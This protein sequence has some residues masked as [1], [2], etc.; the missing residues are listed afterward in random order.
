MI[1]LDHKRLALLGLG[2][3]NRAL[4]AYLS[5]QGHSFA[6][7]DARER[8]GDVA[9]I[10]LGA[11]VDD[12]RLGSR[13]LERLEDFDLV[14]RTPGLPAL[15]PQLAAA[16]AAGVQVSSQTALFFDRCPAPILGVTGTKGKGTTA[17]LVAL[18]LGAD[19]GYGRVELGGNIGRAPID[20]L[21][22]LTASDLAV[23]ELSSFQLQD[24]P[25]SPSIAVV[26]NLLTD[27]LDYHADRPEYIEAKK[28][29]YRHQSADDWLITNA[30]SAETA[31]LASDSRARSLLFS[32]AGEVDSGSWVEDGMI[33]HRA[34]G[35]PPEEIGAVTAIA[36]RGSHNV[37]NAVAAVTAA[38]AAGGGKGGVIA[39]L[40]DFEG[41][42]HRLQ[43][44]AEDR[45]VSFHDDSA[46][47]TPD[48]AI[49]A[50]GSFEAPVIL[51]AGGASKGADFRRLARAIAASSVRVLIV[52]DDE[53]DRIAAAVAGTG[54]FAGDT[55]KVKGMETAVATARDR[56][57]PG[58]VVLLSPA[59]ASFG[60][61][62]N[63]VER[64]NAFTAL[65]S[66]GAGA[67]PG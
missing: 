33:W 6:V 67:G 31:G 35:G 21:G 36:L 54:T 22:R 64:G 66:G 30:D 14:F 53:G 52:I 40:R 16:R 3:E 57:R 10:G 9:S 23:L 17:S 11:A 37:A 51:I 32:V 7:C 62:D 65:A 59:C 12:W 44:V 8:G 26:L 48:A 47:T 34:P 24:L 15:H 27:H 49:A 42:P 28:S 25:A 46:A 43:K 39:A 50:I 18:M 29:I 13:Y 19:S 20:F 60:L 61:F 56:A 38:R 2:V 4:A 58:D 1:E 63:Y 41:L 5:S 55:V 45:G